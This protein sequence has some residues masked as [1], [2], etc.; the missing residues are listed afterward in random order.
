MINARAETAHEKPSFRSALKSRRALIPADAYYEWREEALGPKTPFAIHRSDGQMLALAGLW[1]LWSGPDGGD[2]WLSFCLMTI[3]PNAEAG[4]IHDR[5][6]VL[7][8]PDDHGAW[9]S[10][11]TPAADVLSLLR[12]APDS[13]LNT[14][15]VSPILNRAGQDGPEFAARLYATG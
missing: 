10:P 4:Q 9:L 7:I 15:E 6:P 14:T 12:T 3:S 13:M 5:M 2:A 1:E 11:Q 8:E